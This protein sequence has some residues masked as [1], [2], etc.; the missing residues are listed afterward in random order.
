MVGIFILIV[1]F[2][3]QLPVDPGPYWIRVYLAAFIFISTGLSIF[4]KWFREREYATIYIVIIQ[5]NLWLIYLAFSNGL[6][7]IYTICIA[8]TELFCGF[9]FRDFRWVMAFLGGSFLFSLA[10]FGLY[11]GPSPYLMYF[12]VGEIAIIVLL[13]MVLDRIIVD[14]QKL[15]YKSR[16]FR[17]LSDAAFEYSDDGI[18]VTDPQG[19]ILHYNPKFLKIWGVTKEDL[20]SRAPRAG[21]D[22]AK[23]QIVDLEAF[24]A[25]YEESREKPNKYIFQAFQLKD[26]RHLERFSRP[27][28]YKDEHLGRI[29]FYKDVTQSKLRSDELERQKN[30]LERQN[31]ALAEFAASEVVQSGHLEEALHQIAETGH[32][33]LDLARTVVWF[34]NEETGNYR[35]MVAIGVDLDTKLQEIDLRKKENTDFLEAM[36]GLR[37]LGIT[38][39][40]NDPRFHHIMEKYPE[41]LQRARII[42]PLRLQGKLQGFITFQDHN[43]E[44]HWDPNELRFAAS[45]SDVATTVL[46]TSKRSEVEEQLADSLAIL[47]SVFE[48]RGVGIVITSRKGEVM[49]YNADFV[50]MWDLKPEHI[51]PGGKEKLIAHIHSQYHSTE[52]NRDEL[53]ALFKDLNLSQT[54]LLHMKDGRL[55]ERSTRGLWVDGK[56]R[57]RIWYYQDITRRVKSREAL[58]TS[59]RRSRAIVNAVPDLMLLLTPSGKIINRTLP[60]KSVLSPMFQ[61]SPE[62]LQETLPEDVFF[63]IMAAIQETS[64]DREP[65]E[66]ELQMEID[67]ESYDFEIRMVYGGEDEVLAI[68]RDVTYRKTTERELIQRNFELD[69]FVYRA[70]HDLKAPLNSLMGIIDI[71]SMEELP[72]E[73]VTYIGL[74]DRSVVKLDTFIRNLTDFSRI[75]RLEIKD[76]EVDFK[77]LFEEVQESL[78]HMQDAKRCKISL[79]VNE[80]VPWFGDRFHLGIVLANLLSNAIKYQDH[81]KPEATIEVRVEVDENRTQLEVEDNGIGIED[82]YQARLFELF[83]RASNQSFG[84]GLGL[85][86]T[87]NAVEKMNG[88]V[89]IRSEAGKGTCFTIT[90]PNHLPELVLKG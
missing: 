32:Q 15:E 55:I 64:L 71:L 16:Q 40:K 20:S 4:V 37:V 22:K 70:S 27:L 47:T 58:Q 80:K 90:V 49:D 2:I 63:P 23:D 18:I 53:V 33:V 89:A 17:T 60:K 51:A 88:Q 69:S 72:P 57:G 78:M 75:T 10:L 29:W 87:K 62:S 14:R 79:E 12:Y 8:L 76:Q 25:L 54:D 77:E 74:M 6:H 38:N 65:T 21:F 13:L 7:P 19:N 24:N 86:I 50:D 48:M 3:T 46:E 73:I 45:I 52:A 56:P 34:L 61:D 39:M 5:I 68:I 36:E 59:E 35:R 43:V 9:L 28:F 41:I 11:E 30:A 83:F 42:I 66:L 85:Y 26:G 81:S 44:R 84:S 82:Q 67:G 1:P 31:E